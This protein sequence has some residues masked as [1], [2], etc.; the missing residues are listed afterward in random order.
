MLGQREEEVER[1]L[2]DRDNGLLLENRRY[3]SE[4]LFQILISSYRL[5]GDWRFSIFRSAWFS[6]FERIQ[7]R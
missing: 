2:Q 5:M 4:L 7:D 3:G 1:F 6:F